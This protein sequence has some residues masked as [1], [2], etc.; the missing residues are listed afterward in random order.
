[1]VYKYGD[2]IRLK[3]DVM[4]QLSL[5]AETFFNLP[6]EEDEYVRECNNGNGSKIKTYWGLPETAFETDMGYVYLNS[7]Y[8]KRFVWGVDAVI[9]IH[10]DFGGYEYDRLNINVAFDPEGV[11]NSGAFCSFVN[12][13]DIVTEECDNTKKDFKKDI[14]A[15]IEKKGDND[16][17][18]TNRRV[19]HK[20]FGAGEIDRIGLFGNRHVV[21]VRF[22]GSSSESKPVLKGDLM[23]EEAIVDRSA[24]NLIPKQKDE[25]MG[26]NGIDDTERKLA[27]IK[28][29]ERI[30]ADKLAD[31]NEIENMSNETL[32][33][34]FEIL[35]RNGAGHGY[36][37]VLFMKRDMVKRMNRGDHL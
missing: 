7:E 21:F 27:H 5:D 33:D 11:V 25:D 3:D 28:E 24:E 29:M 18:G 31:L 13:C 16:M 37:R 15:V 10:D 14:G 1:M 22:D 9:R 6:D 12:W 20:E 35:I 34:E 30:Q 23:P 19:V 32:V 17:A 8:A 2:T 36:R 4:P 26:K